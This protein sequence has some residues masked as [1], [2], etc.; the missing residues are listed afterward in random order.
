MTMAEVKYVKGYPTDVLENPGTK[1]AEAL[2][3]PSRYRLVLPTKEFKKDQRAED[4]SAWEYEQ[5]DQKNRINVD[6]GAPGGT[7]KGIACFSTGTMNCP[8][9]VG[10]RDGTSEEV[11]VEKLGTPSRAQIDGV[12]KKIEYDSFN[13]WFYLEKRQV[14]YL[15]VSLHT[16]D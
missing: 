9:L 3:P 13:T 15:G 5:P 11:V 6:F 7:V 16:P 8:A 2:N 4:Y 10:I 1:V 12:T 14:Y